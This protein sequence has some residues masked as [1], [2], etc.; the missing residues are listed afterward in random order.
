[1][2]ALLSTNFSKKGSPQRSVLVYRISGRALFGVQKVAF[3]LETELKHV[4][5][6]ATKQ[7][8]SSIDGLPTDPVDPHR[9]RSS[10]L[11]RD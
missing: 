3:A 7:A 6:G 4:T 11:P 2:L 10:R 8:S 1:M 5:R 9:P